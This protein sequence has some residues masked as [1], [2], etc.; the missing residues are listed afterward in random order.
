MKGA[1]KRRP[2]QV[3]TLT[4][5]EMNKYTQ[6]ACRKV[7]S[8]FL[9]AAIEEFTW[10]TGDIDRFCERLRRYMDAV[11]EHLIS[12]STIEEILSDEL[13]ADIFTDLY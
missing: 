7:L 2:K 9:A 6:S 5:S 4:R 1:K 11:D 13:G 8:V 10:D 3:Y 12:L